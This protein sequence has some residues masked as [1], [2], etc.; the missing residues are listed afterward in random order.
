MKKVE[1]RYNERSWAI[2]IISYINSLIKP[3]DTIQ[4]VSGEY[5]LSTENQTL[6]PDVLLFG[7]RSLG[8][9]LQGWEL[10]MPDTSINDNELIS[11]A[12]IKAKNLGLNSFLLWNAKEVRLHIYDSVT[13][14]F[15]E[16]NSFSFRNNLI[17]NRV[18]VQNR[19][20][21][22]QKDVRKIIT[23][24]NAYFRTG[25]IKAATAQIVFSDEGLIS[26]VLSCHAEVSN[27]LIQQVKKDKKIDANIKIWWRYVKNEYPGYNSPYS[28]LAYCI[29][30]RWFNRFVFANILKAYNRI[31]FDG[32]AIDINTS[33]PIALSTFREI[34][35]KNDYWNILGP[36][37]F[38]E[39]VPLD[40]W[41]KLMAT[42]QIMNEF[43]FSKI[44]KSV[45]KEI[46]KSVV[47]TS[48][49]KT[50]GLYSTPKCLA[51]LL[52]RLALND[53]DGHVIDPFCG[54]GTIVKS[55]LEVKSDYNIDGQSAVKTT[56]ACDKFAF[57]IQIATL[58][59]A[60][61]E[62]MH[63]PL[64]IFTHDAFTLEQGEKIVLIDPT[65]GQSKENSIPKFSAIISNF[66]FVQFEDVAELNPIVTNKIDDFY[67]IHNI[68]KKERMDGRSDLYAYIP[69]LLYD[70]LEDDG[71][72]GM[73]ISNSWLATKTSKKF[74]DLLSKYY[75]IE[76]VVT[77]G[78][79]KWFN[80]T[81][82]VTNLVICKK[83][84]NAV[85]EVD[86]NTVYVTVNK[87][88]TE[89]V[90]G[91]ELSA[92]IIT[93]NLTS[94]LV[95]LSVYNAEQ[96]KAIK[97]LN[98]SWN[99]CFGNILWLINNIDK[100]SLLNSYADIIRGER[101]GWDA[102]FYLSKD[103]SNSIENEYLKPVLKT[104]KGNYEYVI[105]ADSYAFC[106]GVLK[107]K[108][109]Q[110][111]HFGA[112]NW[113]E[114]FEN[115]LNGK[116]KLL[117]KVLSRPNLLWYQF[118]DEENIMPDF[119][120]SMS[121]DTRI[122]I[123]RL[124]NCKLI[125]QRLIGISVKDKSNIDFFHALLNST[126]VI[127]QIEG[128]GFGR[129]LSVLDIN[130]TNLKSGLYIPQIDLFTKGNKHEIIS[131]FQTMISKPILPIDQELMRPDRMKLDNLILEA[132]GLN[133]S[134]REEIY[135]G[136]LKMYQIR[137]SVKCK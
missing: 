57:P 55:I 137:K 44:D 26:Q 93:N 87:K 52:V 19:P 38:D 108:L 24:L 40:A 110:K 27:F 18:D 89:I 47:L 119:V 80:N 86:Y 83:I 51:D 31:N 6:F 74:R 124:K 58:A 7:D 50:A 78:A 120:L 61:P 115:K 97:K 112:L 84:K 100:F 65:N 64:K 15:K 96:L 71:Y 53:K 95:S 94:S 81:D 113:I 121:P 70:L 16:E 91:E 69:F 111:K 132:M 133:I 23:N 34:S 73:I 30:L 99:V 134:I 14:K 41:K 114:S 1:L 17:Q 131:C 135:S 29:I 2:D 126:I 56:W 10:K 54:T 12:A 103:Q 136:F 106:C 118:T 62:I 48:I 66:P 63:E 72:L 128:L 117:R 101:R 88:L 104:S 77:S 46:I 127:C 76:Y 125:N 20:D 116:G 21:L 130:P 9:I 35:Q 45:L 49:K 123:Q 105:Q 122:F 60:T 92:D 67:R 22:W 4:H 36:N 37:E 3:E 32:K 109:K 33:I 25:K 59:I 79:E 42:F 85:S 107:E 82:V 75:H 11:N 68:S 129:G 39:Y 102:M 8:T 98:L 13:N 43:E 28:P 5:S 90:D